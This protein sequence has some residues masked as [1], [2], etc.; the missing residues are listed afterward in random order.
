MA[1]IEQTAH[2]QASTSM[3]TAKT[4]PP[5]TT[6]SSP[7]AAAGSPPHHDL[8]HV[9]SLTSMPTGTSSRR[10]SRLVSSGS[11]PSSPT[12]VHSS[13]SAI[14][15]R[16]IEAPVSLHP[17]P[18]HHHQQQPSAS[19]I[20]SPGAHSPNCSQHNPHLIPRAHNTLEHSVPSVLDSAAAVLTE[21]SP[22]EVEEISVVT[23]AMHAPSPQSRGQS[24]RMS[25][26]G[27]GSPSGT[28]RSGYTRSPSPAL[29]REGLML[30]IP[31]PPPLIRED[32]NTRSSPTTSAYFSTA[33]SPSVS[34]RST[35]IDLDD[36]DTTMHGHARDDTVTTRDR[37][38]TI[39]GGEKPRQ[40]STST[41]ASV[42]SA[43]SHTINKRLSFISYSD[44]L[45]STPASTVPLAALT[46]NLT[47]ADV[48]GIDAH[49]PSPGGS[50]LLGGPATFGGGSGSFGGSV[51][52]GSVGAGSA[53]GSRA[54]SLRG[55]RDS[56]Y[57][58]SLELSLNGIAVAGTSASAEWEREGMGR[59]LEERLLA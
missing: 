7:H 1:S 58:P 37:G 59:G 33:S 20:S 2:A 31:H 17:P 14:F 9:T 41:M 11:I 3:A 39:R 44:L 57:L 43:A 38:A 13:E 18:H 21:L 25:M 6:P 19:P 27:I 35:Q 49:G 10:A 12:S 29:G 52:S 26:L 4:S 34:P 23:P 48:E 24:P 32:S 28:V 16:D 36:G 42:A 22:Q 15:E 5:G 50:P 40:S 53:A 8:R 55:N 30:N 45:A 47:S 56:T 46:S 51:T 54:A